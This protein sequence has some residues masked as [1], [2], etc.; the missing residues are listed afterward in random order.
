[1]S[2]LIEIHKIMK[3][4]PKPH[5]RNFVAKHAK[6]AGAGVHKDKAGEHAPRHRQKQQWKK[7][8]HEA[9]QPGE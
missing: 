3:D 4:L 9:T 7:E 5:K 6:R 1:M 2:L 8:M